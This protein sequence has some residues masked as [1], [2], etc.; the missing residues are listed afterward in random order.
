MNNAIIASGAN[1]L[2]LSS[3][4]NFLLLSG[5]TATAARSTSTFSSFAAF[6]FSHVSSSPPRPRSVFHDSIHYQ[7]IK[8]IY[9]RDDGRLGTTTICNVRTHSSGIDIDDEKE[10]KKERR[11]QILKE[12]KKNK[13]KKNTKNKKQQDN[14]MFRAERV[15]ATR[16]CI[17]RSEASTIIKSRKVAYRE[18]DDDSGNPLT[19][20]RTTKLKIPMN[21][22]IYIEGK[23]LPP[24]PPS[25]I[26]YHKPRNVLSAMD[27]K[28]SQTKKHLGMFLPESYK[29]F[30]MHPVGR[31]DY[32]TSGL[33]LFSR[34]GDLTQRLL[35]PK[36]KI[37]KE[38]VA[39]VSGGPVN[40]DTLK[41]KLE[42]DGVET[43]E[44][45]HHAKLV[46]VEEIN[47]NESEL[48]LK[49]YL[50]H[51]ENQGMEE[52]D[53]RIISA[54]KDLDSS[55]D[56]PLSNIKLVVQEGKYRMVRRMLANCGH[57]VLELK[58]ERH[59]EVYLND[60][61]IGEFRDCTEDELHWAE[62]L[63]R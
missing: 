28:H 16:A 39:T 18:I 9:N 15:V 17:S 24:I 14:E 4:R 56:G 60:L 32:D 34:N 62:G 21:A 37:E 11:R 23:P 7:N 20:I 45:V 1:L 44:G 53:E 10:E 40:Y 61:E 41:Q 2:L 54:S 13:N 27:E 31:L 63:L 19:P 49:N 5:A 6:G 57:P 8:Q 46:N 42:V 55:D 26:V 29:K 48:I 30:G 25:L 36:Y 22:I 51:K 50:S 12:K 3:S 47:R 38:Y 33:I 35:H 52:R 43:T 58:R 59:G